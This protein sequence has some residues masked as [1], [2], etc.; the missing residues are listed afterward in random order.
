MQR[1]RFLSADGLTNR[2]RRNRAAQRP[3][4]PRRAQ[5]PLRLRRE[6]QYG[7]GG[8][9]HASQHHERGPSEPHAAQRQLVPKSWAFLG[10][11]GLYAAAGNFRAMHTQG[12]GAVKPYRPQKRARFNG[13]RH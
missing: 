2:T 6:T 13:L 3:R 5:V 1:A 12:P 9:N 8:A 4:T 7:D 10:T 11:M